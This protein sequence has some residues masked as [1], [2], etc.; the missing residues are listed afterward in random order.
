MCWVEKLPS[1]YKCTCIHSIHDISH[2][3]SERE[4]ERE[5]EYTRH[6]TRHMHFSPA[7]RDATHTQDRDPE[8]RQGSH[9]SDNDVGEDDARSGR[10]GGG[11]GGA[12]AAG[13]EGARVKRCYDVESCAASTKALDATSVSLGGF[14]AA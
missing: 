4:R 9:A 12:A 8:T 14:G 10:G 1:S 3:M 2:D 13:R 6:I 11:G 7:I 5:R